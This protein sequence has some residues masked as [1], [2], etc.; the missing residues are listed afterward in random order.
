VVV[1]ISVIPIS[2]PRVVR[3]LA[4]RTS[5]G[6]HSIIFRCPI[7]AHIQGRLHIQAIDY[8][9][10]DFGTRSLVM[11]SCDSSHLSKAAHRT[12]GNHR[13]S[14]ALLGVN[15]PYSASSVYWVRQRRRQCY[16]GW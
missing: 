10:A 12:Y 16:C 11:V 5:R 3:P 13:Q 4:R 2:M 1:C 14:R 6:C 15:D 8:P 7:S 9:S